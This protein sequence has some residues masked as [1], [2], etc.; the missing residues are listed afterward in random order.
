M[1][2]ASLVANAAGREAPC[3]RRRPEVTELAH[4]KSNDIDVAL[5]WDREQDGLLVIVEDFRT[6]DRFSW[7]LTLSLSFYCFQALTY[8]IDLYRR[9][10][11]AQATRN[12][13][14]YLSSALF[15][16]VLVAGPIMRAML[17][18][19]WGE[20]ESLCLGELPDPPPPWQSQ[21]LCS[22]S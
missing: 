5:L 13:L 3:N 16:P 9:D 12:L 8:T 1:P 6:G 18:R 10:D 4:R 19:D 15:F 2:A 17:C 21:S 20:P 11:D 7:L 14:A 22:P